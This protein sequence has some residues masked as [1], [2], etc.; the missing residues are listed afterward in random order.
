MNDNKLS[1]ISTSVN[2]P[3][4]VAIE[5]L[6]RVRSIKD[7]Q[8]IL[9]R[10]LEGIGLDHVVY[11]L[12]KATYEPENSDTIIMTYPSNWVD[13]YFSMNYLKID[14]VVIT[15]K[16][17][18]CQLIGKVYLCVKRKLSNFLEKRK[19]LVLVLTGLHLM[20]ADRKCASL[21]SR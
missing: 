15:S 4:E 14:P 5:A 18:F 16:I 13:R 2:A 19:S 8:V 11:Y 3:Y 12:P 10:L 6:S 20:Y 17:L 1:S 21:Y 9:E 7:A